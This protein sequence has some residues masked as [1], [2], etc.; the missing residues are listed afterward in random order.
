MAFSQALLHSEPYVH[1]LGAM[2]GNQ[3]MQQV[4]SSA[5]LVPAVLQPILLCFCEWHSSIA[6]CGIVGDAAP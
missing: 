4:R 6:D 5:I 3:A 1:S 2:T